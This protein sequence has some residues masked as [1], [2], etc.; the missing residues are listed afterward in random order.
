MWLLVLGIELNSMMISDSELTDLSEADLHYRLCIANL[1][2]AKRLC[3]DMIEEKFTA[4]FSHAKV[5]MSL[6]HHGIELFLKYAL[7]RRRKIPRHHYIRE[8]LKEY[9]QAYS[10]PEFALELPFITQFFGYTPDEM[11]L[12]IAEEQ[13]EKNRTDQMV[14]YHTD[15]N[16]KVWTVAQ[17]FVPEAFLVEAEGLLHRFVCI[18]QDIEKGDDQQAHAPNKA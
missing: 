16:G 12:L 4:S 6:L 17:A 11:G 10:G 13:Q 8:L 3:Q 1:D 2:G 14:R 15:R 18:R 9:D 7:A 5:I